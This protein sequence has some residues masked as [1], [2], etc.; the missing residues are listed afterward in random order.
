MNDTPGA[1]IRP[2]IPLSQRELE[3]EDA[4]VTQQEQLQ[5]LPDRQPHRGPSGGKRRPRTIAPAPK[6]K[7]TPDRHRVQPSDMLSVDEA[8]ELARLLVD[9]PVLCK[10]LGVEL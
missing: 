6:D 8:V 5:G 10:V 9:H 4:T 1:A 3:E 2:A 7:L